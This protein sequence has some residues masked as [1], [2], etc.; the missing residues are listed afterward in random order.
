MNPGMLFCVSCQTTRFSFKL[1]LR[2]NT[3]FKKVSWLLL[4]YVPSISMC[5]AT[6]S[7]SLMVEVFLMGVLPIFSYLHDCDK[8]FA[9]L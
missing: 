5:I 7:I 1:L 2:N 9:S 6:Y 4:R 3:S 8:N